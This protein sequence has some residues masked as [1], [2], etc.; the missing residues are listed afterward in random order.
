MSLKIRYFNV[1]LLFV[2]LLFT[3]SCR[4]YFSPLVNTFYGELDNRI[5]YCQLKHLGEDKAIRY[6]TDRLSIMPRE[7]AR[8]IILSDTIIV[9]GSNNNDGYSELIYGNQ[10]LFEY[11]RAENDSM[12]VALKLQSNSTNRMILDIVRSNAI[13]SIKKL[14]KNS[15]LDNSDEVDVLIIIQNYSNNRQRFKHIYIHF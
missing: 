4:I 2:L 6:S 3:Y 1:F 7:I 5:K 11:N 14:K 15:L 10:L 8:S 9:I 12:M 13:S